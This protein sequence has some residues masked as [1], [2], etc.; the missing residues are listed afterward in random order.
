MFQSSGQG[1]INIYRLTG[2]YIL[3]VSRGLSYLVFSNTNTQTYEIF[4]C[5]KIKHQVLKLCRRLKAQ[6]H[7]FTASTVGTDYSAYCSRRFTCRKLSSVIHFIGSWIVCSAYLD[8]LEKI[9]RDLFCPESNSDP[10]LVQSM[11]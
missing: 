3:N 4:S 5:I 1:V 11:S 9:R 10:S 7:A 6:L 2:A 8:V